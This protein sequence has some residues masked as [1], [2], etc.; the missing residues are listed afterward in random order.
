VAALFAAAGNMAA[1]AESLQQAHLLKPG[2]VELHIQ[3]GWPVFSFSY[4]FS[5]LSP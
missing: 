1:A 2:D 5:S 3:L 4:S